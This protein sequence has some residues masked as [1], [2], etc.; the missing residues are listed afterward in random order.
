M[1]QPVERRRNAVTQQ[2]LNM[3]HLRLDNGEKR[4]GAIEEKLDSNSD[5]LDENTE[6]TKDVRELLEVGRAGFKVLGWLGKAATWFTGV[7]GAGGILY[8]VWHYFVTGKPPG[9]K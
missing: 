2:D 1:S 6:M 7:A 9:F 5:K 3:I 8:T 4:M